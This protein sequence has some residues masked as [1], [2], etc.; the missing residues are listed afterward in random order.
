MP[1]VSIIIPVYNRTAVFKRAVES[2]LAQTYRDFEL[3]IVDDGSTIDVKKYLPID[4]RIK[5]IKQKHRGVSAARN[6]GLKL[7]QGQYICFLDS[8]DRWLPKKLEKQLAYL[9]QHPEFV[10]AQ[11]EEIWLRN[12]QRVNA[13]KKHAKEAGDI[14]ERSLELCLVSPSAVI[15]KKELLNEVGF[16]DE[17]LPACEDYDLWLRIT[18]KYPVGLLKENLIEKYGGHA[19]QL[20]HLYPVMDKFRV[21]SIRK[22][23]RE[24]ALLPRQRGQALN[25]L[26]QKS[27][28]IAQ[29]A[30]KRK[31]FLTGI[32][33]FLLSAHSSNRYA[34]L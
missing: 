29:G 5:F 31:K 11:T 2:V 20:S 9:R 18:A 8:D 19:D 10:I 13:M 25:V 24:S 32:Y 7:A 14:F 28:V 1:S 17:T 21:K 16:F 27:R 30:W 23:L 12:G 15:I 6:K 4:P 3:I 34:L 26:A 22:L 33:Y